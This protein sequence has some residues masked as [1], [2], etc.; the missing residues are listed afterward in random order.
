MYFDYH[1]LYFLLQKS[2]VGCRCTQMYTLVNMGLI[3]GVDKEE[4]KSS[5]EKYPSCKMENTEYE[6]KHFMIEFIFVY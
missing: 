4:K 3:S 1:A 5:L 2:D 6:K